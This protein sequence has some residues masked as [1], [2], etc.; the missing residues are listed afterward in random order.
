MNLPQH[1]L[2]RQTIFATLRAYKQHD[3]NWRSGKLLAG[4]YDPG[5]DNA[6]TIKEAYTEFLT[7]NALFLN[8]Y[9]SVI[10]LENDVTR[11]VINLLQGENFKKLNHF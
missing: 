3:V 2:D 1:G 6:A 5:D 9:P 4:V 8:F 10:Q 11:M 7:E